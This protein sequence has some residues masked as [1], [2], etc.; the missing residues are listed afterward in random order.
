MYEL[1]IA[2]IASFI[3]LPAISS[4]TPTLFT[5][6]TTYRHTISNR[7]NAAVMCILA[8]LTNSSIVDLLK[9]TVLAPWPCDARRHYST[10]HG[11]TLT[12]TIDITG[13]S[14]RVAG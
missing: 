6:S 9:F 11:D 5:P 3:L 2:V 7:S 1:Q 14:M 10:T 13:E 8:R 4:A 12:G